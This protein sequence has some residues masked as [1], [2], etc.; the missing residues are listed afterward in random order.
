M[1]FYFSE[2]STSTKA[3]YTA[4]HC[5]FLKIKKVT[6]LSACISYIYKK[7]GRLLLFFLLST[8]ILKKVSTIRFNK[9]RKIRKICL[10]KY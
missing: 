4:M 7:F 10:E 5:I 3:S 6:K 8:T 2:A 1:N 9:F